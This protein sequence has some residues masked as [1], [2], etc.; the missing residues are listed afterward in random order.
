MEDVPMI[1]QTT[2]DQLLQSLAQLRNA[3]S[4]LAL[5]VSDFQFEHD[6]KSCA[7]AAEHTERLLNAI[8]RETM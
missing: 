6:T 7:L 4:E 8:R 3:L 1:S 2:A 5:M